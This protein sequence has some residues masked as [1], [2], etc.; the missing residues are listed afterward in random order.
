M[1]K[2]F[3]TGTDT[4]VGKTF[5]TSSFLKLLSIEN[6][7]CFGLKPIASGCEKIDGKWMNEDALSLMKNS[8]IE[9]S[10]DDVNPIALPE[11]I[12]PHLAAE[13]NNVAINVRAIS[14]HCKKI[15]KASESAADC[16]IVEGAGGWFVPL[17]NEET[18]ADAVKEL[19]LDVL[20]VVGIRLGC[21]NHAL[22]T[23]AAIK[24]S[25][26]RLA[27]W[28]ANTIDAGASNQQE[29]VQTLRQRINAPCLG[30][31]PNFSK[32]KEYSKIITAASQ[33]LRMP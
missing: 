20:L 23:E 3:V 18:Y 32:N 13:K 14:E 15:F 22:L 5:V 12:A 9:L 26:L 21:I 27:G 11:A 31:V 8:S 1:K 19:N 16:I 4:E 30:V 6:K 28:V 7:K 2:Y 29:I 17:N 25:G 24:Q 10:Y 33:Y